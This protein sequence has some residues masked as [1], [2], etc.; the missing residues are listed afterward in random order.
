MK[1]NKEAM[2]KSIRA[3]VTQR[4]LTISDKEISNCLDEAQDMYTQTKDFLPKDQPLIQT[5]TSAFISG[6]IFAIDK[7]DREKKVDLHFESKDGGPLK[8]KG[9]T[10]S[11]TGEE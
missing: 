9:E 10:P 1:I 8:Y 11:Q 2:S 6:V 3:L 5:M 7:F 4:G